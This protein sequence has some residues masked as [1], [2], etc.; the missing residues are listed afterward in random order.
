MPGD[1]FILTHFVRNF[2]NIW[3]E[4]VDRL[5]IMLNMDHRMPKEVKEYNLNYLDAHEKIT[6]IYTEE[7]LFQGAAIREI[8]PIVQEDTL[9]LIEDDTVIVIKG[10]VDRGFRYIENGDAHVVGSPRFSCSKEILDASAEK[11]G[12]DYSGYGDK[13]PNMWPNF[14]FIKKEHLLDTDM[15]FEPKQW[16]KGDRI[17]ELDITAEGT[18]AA[19]VFVWLCIQLRAK[20]LKFKDIPQYH[21]HPHDLKDMRNHMNLW[22]G[23]CPWVH[24]G[25]LTMT[26]EDLILQTLDLTDHKNKPTTDLEQKEMERRLAWIRVMLYKTADMNTLS[27]L[28]HSYS[29]RI[30]EMI[31]RWGLNQGHMY[32]LEE[33]YK[34]FYRW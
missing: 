13:G 3:A 25:S 28:R 22:D 9:F 16:E 17:E 6:P 34:S 27:D 8:L 2:D 29:E 14:F 24:I 12:L 15:H 32:Q 10:Q 18:I 1:P 31:F 5:Y 33:A 11:Y 30:K 4:E 23:R 19:D 26:I 20:G 21:S 7:M